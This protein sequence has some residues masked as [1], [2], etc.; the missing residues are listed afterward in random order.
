LLRYRY[1]DQKNLL[2]T[3]E[4]KLIQA[5]INPHFLFNALNTISA[6][7]SEDAPRPRDLLLQHSNLF[8]K[9]L[10][11]TSD[12]STL[13]EELNHVN[14]YLTIEKARFEDRLVVEETID[15][16]LLG[17]RLPTFTL[18]PIIENAIKHG[19]SAM[20]GVGIIKVTA[21]KNGPRVEI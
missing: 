10:K 14:S 19:V 1:E 8:R 16:E 21:R 12:I 6:V 9:N 18:Q 4:L 13:E 2:L 17:T 7:I 5:Q 20:F 11:R 3:S 15:P